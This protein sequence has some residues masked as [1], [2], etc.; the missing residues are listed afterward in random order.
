MLYISRSQK[1]LRKCPNQRFQNQKHSYYF[2]SIP[3]AAFVSGSA[4][5]G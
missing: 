5:V 4:R 1:L 2:I 3:V